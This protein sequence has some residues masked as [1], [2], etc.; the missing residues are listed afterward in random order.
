M[1]EENQYDIKSKSENLRANISYSYINT[2]EIKSN[3]LNTTNNITNISKINPFLSNNVNYRNLNNHNKSAIKIKNHNKNNNYNI[4]SKSKNWIKN[5]M[6]EKLEQKILNNIDIEFQTKD[7]MN[8]KRELQNEL[9]NAKQQ[10]KKDKK[11]I[12]LLK[13]TINN[14]MS[15]NNKNI[16]TNVSDNKNCKNK[17]TYAD[18]LLSLEKVK[19][20]N[21][22]LKE[23]LNLLTNEKNELLGVKNKYINKEKELN[24]YILK[25]EDLN[26]K[27]EILEK[28]T[29]RMG[30]NMKK[31]EKFEEMKLDNESL[32][33]NLN[34][35]NKE[36]LRLKNELKEKN[37]EIN[38]LKLMK[39]DDKLYFL[40][41]ELYK[42]KSKDEQNQINIEKLTS[43][44][45]D[46]KKKLNLTTQLLE[47]EQ[48]TI[49]EN[50][51][52]IED[53]INKYNDL[54]NKYDS[55]YNIK[56][57]M[58]LENNE[59]K[60]KNTQINAVLIQYKNNYT[61]YKD[62]LK[63]LSNQLISLKNEK[64]KN[65]TYYL[66]QIA[67]IQK[68]KNLVENQLNKVREQNNCVNTNNYDDLNNNDYISKAKY[69]LSL[70]EIKTYHNDNKKLFDLSK[71]LKNDINFYL[72]EKEF[73]KEIIN[74]IIKGNYI[75]S[76]YSEFIDL[77]QNS[78]ENFF[79]IQ[80]LNKL[81]YDYISKLKKY[82]KIMNSMNRKIFIL[83]IIIN[84]FLFVFF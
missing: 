57:N 60:L 6:K 84:I 24:D 71:K 19:D 33:M 5:T 73:Y 30:E 58:T 56:E 78:L 55:L 77:I 13:R 17:N 9:K 42:Y 67:L 47:E 80:R 54:K 53:N 48:Y 75:N 50:R 18:L 12:E 43:E 46:N 44:L 49:K 61:N 28:Q 26:S 2:N 27:Y 82:E 22:I 20:E 8:V 62:E 51:T 29:L 15:E 23:K 79:D 7:L 59:L 68:E 3:N 70:Q 35:K 63:N 11:N 69:E 37:K 64:N 21:N 76:K 1:T 52:Q 16:I 74:K 25:N 72:E 4:K 36:N 31:I 40:E 83:F 45:N 66:N 10:M 34:L 14:L 32:E 38:E 65:E 39:Y 81:K 41:T